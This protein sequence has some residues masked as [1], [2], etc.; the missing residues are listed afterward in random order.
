MSNEHIHDK[1]IHR[2]LKASA[3]YVYSPNDGQFSV[4]G[5]IV[6]I[7]FKRV[8]GKSVPSI[9]SVAVIIIFNDYMATRTGIY[10]SVSVNCKN[11]V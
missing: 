8:Y 9:P 6:Q 7:S 11:V 5:N 2:D 4:Y 3:D 10:I 1:G